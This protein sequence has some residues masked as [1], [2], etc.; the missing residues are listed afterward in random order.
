MSSILHLSP[1]GSKLSYFCLSGSNLDPDPQHLTGAQQKKT[2]R[3]QILC[4][5]CSICIPASNLI[6]SACITMW[7]LPLVSSKARRHSSSI[8]KQQVVYVVSKT[9]V[10]ISV[11]FSAREKTT[12]PTSEVQLGQSTDRKE[13]A[14]QA[15]RARSNFLPPFFCHSHCNLY[16]VRL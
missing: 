13:R 4:T 14:W 11:L 16:A 7:I 9:V 3:E 1:L 2:K 10:E 15:G 6:L 8:C 5:S 12:S